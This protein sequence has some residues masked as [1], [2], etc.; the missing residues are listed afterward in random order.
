[1]LRTPSQ[2]KNLEKFSARAGKNFCLK[3]TE[4]QFILFE[5]ISLFI[6]KTFENFRLFESPTG[7]SDK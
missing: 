2:R 5:A 4:G 1:M 7:I 6:T 3:V